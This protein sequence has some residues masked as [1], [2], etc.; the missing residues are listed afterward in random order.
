TGGL[1]V[2]DSYSLTKTFLAPPGFTGDFHLFVK[3]DF[4]NKVFENGQ[5]S[6]NVAES[7]EPFEI[8]PIPYAD[9]VV[10]SLTPG[11]SPSSGQPL[12]VTWEVTNQGI[13]QTNQGN[14][15]DWVELATDAAGTNRIALL[16]KFQHF[17]HLAVDGS[18][19]RTGVVTLPDGLSGTYYL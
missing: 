2:N 12:A 10:S 11:A 3:T 13:G 4:E 16:G 19:S 9:L 7:D 18:Y 6:N 14:W 8:M 15:V 1:A 5:E 17:G